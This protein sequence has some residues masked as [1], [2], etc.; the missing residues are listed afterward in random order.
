MLAHQLVGLVLDGIRAPEEALH[1]VRKAQPYRNI[2]K[3][4]FVEVIERLQSQ[5]L[6]W[7]E[8]EKISPRKRSWQYYY[9]NLSMIPDIRRYHIRNSISGESIGTLDEEFVV[10]N[11]EPGVTF[12]CK[13]EA[14]EVI[15]V[16]DDEVKVEPTKDP[17][18]AIPAWGGELIP[19][20][21]ETAQEVGELRAKV[22]KSLEEGQEKMEIVES[23]GN[24][25][26]VTKDA[27]ERSVKYLQNHIE[28]A[29][30]PTDKRIVL[31]TYKN[32]AV[33]HAAFG[34]VTNKTLAQILSALLSARIGASVGVRSD[35]YRIAFR[36][37][38]RSDAEIVEETLKSFEA[39]HVEPL[40]K[41]VLRKS[42]I[43]R[44]KLL[45]VA[46]RFGAIRKDADFSEIRGERLVKAYENTPLW[47]ETEREVRLEKLNIPKLKS[48][49]KS[50]QSGDITLEKTARGEKKGPTPIGLPILNELAMGGELVVPERTEREILKVLKRGLRNKRVKL[51]C[52]HCLDWSTLTRARRLPDEPTCKNCGAKLLGLVPPRSGEV[53]KALEKERRN[54]ELGEKEEHKV[55]RDKETANMILTYGKKAVITMD[56]RGVGPKTAAR[57][58]RKQYKNEDDFY[59]EILRS[60]RVYAR[61]HR[62]WD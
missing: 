60:E 1:L 29:P 58:L 13:G 36:F 50:M 27:L 44:W 35:S 26:P 41:K 59:R 40:L 55:K 48:I 12:I 18:G 14:W 39:E 10:S 2:D 11:A 21:F 16:E 25:Y 9:E 46:K 15:E 31:E 24:E 17:Y 30:I 52:I 23:L 54:E 6:L 53:E 20:D 57:I 47:K 45:H 61:T 8:G 42:S 19:V 33:L 22:E 51:L 38:K 34:T 32:F 5:G 43:F 56:G 4:E 7:R 28:E 37:P 62:F 49:I 3:D